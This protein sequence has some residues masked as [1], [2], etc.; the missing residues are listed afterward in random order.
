MVEDS[1]VIIMAET[2]TDF[3][4]P[5]IIIKLITMMNTLMEDILIL[6][7]ISIKV[8][9]ELVL[10]TE[11]GALY[12]TEIDRKEIEGKA[13]TGEVEVTMAEL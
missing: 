1:E 3:P 5:I 4:M 13:I 10:H 7:G 6:I 12:K 8:K 2:G 9:A 11:T